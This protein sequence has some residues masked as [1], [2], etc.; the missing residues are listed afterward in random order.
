MFSGKARV[1]DSEA[2][3]RQAVLDG[4]IHTGDVI[5]VRYEGPKGAPGMPEMARLIT[6][7]QSTGLGETVPL[8]TDG[9]FSG[10][11]RGACIGHICPE[12]AVG[13]PLAL[14]EDGDE[15]FCDIDRRLLELRVDDA[16]LAERRARWKGAP[17]KATR[18]Y[19]ARYAKQVTSATRG[20][21]VE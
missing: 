13:G 21:V 9:R 6:L 18:G 12:A 4:E 7:V 20:A 10:I 11:T 3:A 19:L 2:D 5:V 17:V 15:I 1:F 16:Q 8:I 14:V